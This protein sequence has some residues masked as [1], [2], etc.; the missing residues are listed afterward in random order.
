MYVR[1]KG[2]RGWKALDPQTY[3]GKVEAAVLIESV[4]LL[5]QFLIFL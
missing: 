3:R 2:V 1:G 4:F 5:E